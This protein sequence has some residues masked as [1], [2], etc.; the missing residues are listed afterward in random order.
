MLALAPL[1]KLAITVPDA[2]HK[3]LVE[4]EKARRKLVGDTAKSGTLT[5][6]A[7]L[8]IL[9]IFAVLPGIGFEIIAALLAGLGAGCVV[10]GFFSGLWFLSSAS[11]LAF[12]KRAVRQLPPHVDPEF[13]R[14]EPLLSEAAKDWDWQASN[15]RERSEVH[16][17]A[18]ALWRLQREVPSERDE[19]WVEEASD[20]EGEALDAEELALRQEHAELLRRR[21]VIFR[22]HAL[23][24]KG[25]RLA[26]EKA[27]KA[28]PAPKEGT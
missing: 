13:A 26:K 20:L 25:V 1:E 11:W 16:G 22:R 18:R 9:W 8:I 23:F 27:L 21:D 28:L 15:W 12:G 14:L 5:A 10:G 4:A 3:A 7:I 6:A 24:E 19:D 17:Q 2:G